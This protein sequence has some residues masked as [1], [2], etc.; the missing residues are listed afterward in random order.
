VSSYKHSHVYMAHVM[1]FINNQTYTQ[2]LFGIKVHCC[3]SSKSV[4]TS[5]LLLCI[6]MVSFMHPK[7]R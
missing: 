3:I 1:V 5:L 4:L 6:I 2:S 7:L